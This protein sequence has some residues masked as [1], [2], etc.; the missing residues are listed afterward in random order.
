M[1]EKMPGLGNQSEARP[2][3]CKSSSK[4]LIYRPTA[5][6]VDDILRNVEDMMKA[7]PCIT[8]HAVAEELGIGHERD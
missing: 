2:P 1:L 8:V 5:N 6:A 4:Q 7:N 3:V